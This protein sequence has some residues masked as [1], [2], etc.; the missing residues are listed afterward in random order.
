[1]WLHGCLAEY[2]APV[3]WGVTLFYAWF[4][5][6]LGWRNAR[7]GRDVWGMVCVVVSVI[8][9]HLLG[10]INLY[11]IIVE[12]PWWIGVALFVYLA[13]AVP[14][15]WIRV[16]RTMRADYE[17]R[18]DRRPTI[19]ANAV[20][21]YLTRQWLPERH[22]KW[23][24]TILAK[25]PSAESRDGDGSLAIHGRLWNQA[26]DNELKAEVDAARK[27]EPA[28]AMV[29]EALK[30]VGYDRAI[31]VRDYTARAV[32][33]MMWWPLFMS[34]DIVVRWV[35]EL[36]QR[37]KEFWLV[38]QAQFDHLYQGKADRMFEA[39]ERERVR[40]EAEELSAPAA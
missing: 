17:A 18:K 35:F 24:A 21:D 7:K 29:A 25:D 22:R 28:Q 30:K 9:L 15:M 32:S 6:Y 8:G 3:W 2:V 11:S 1:M 26:V 13:V 39:Y 5:L 16:V 33:W 14:Y 37:I 10:G 34:R 4:T 31:R 19:V 36:G 27:S 40:S 20:D 38:V 12:R 23:R